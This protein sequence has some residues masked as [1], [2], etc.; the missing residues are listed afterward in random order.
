LTKR[1][2][3]IALAGNP[4]SGKSSLFNH[5]TGLKQKVSNIPGTSVDSKSGKWEMSTDVEAKVTDLPGIYSLLPSSED[6]RIASELLIRNASEYDLVIFSLDA[7]NVRRGL[8]LY[9]QIA[10]LG[11]PIVV[12]ISMTDMSEKMGVSV[13]IELLAQKLGV[14]IC[15][16]NTRS[17][18]GIK[19]LKS[20]ILK[21]AYG[22][23]TPI[24]EES[25]WELK[26][27]VITYDDVESS[28]ERRYNA[29]DKLLK[30]VVTKKRVDPLAFTKKADKII[31]HPVWGFMVFA[32]V[33]FIVFQLVFSFAEYPMEAIEWAFSSL[34]DFLN[35]RLP[36]NIFGELLVDGVLPG[37]GGVVVFLPQI[38]FL[39]ALLSILEETG[40]MSRVSFITDKIMRKVGLNGRSVIPMVGGLACA[41]PSIMAC[42]NI[43]NTKERLLTMLV[44]PLMS[45]SAR[46]PVYLLVISMLVPDDSYVWLFNTQGL[47]LFGLYILGFVAS[48][49]V[50]FFANIFVR[51]EGVTSYLMELPLYR[52]PQ[53]RTTFNLIWSK[54]ASFVKE[55]GRVILI[56]SVVLWAL[57]SYG[58]SDSMS[59][60]R[61][62]YSKLIY[63]NPDNEL[64][65]EKEMKSKLLEESYAG[66]IGKFI[67]PAIKPMGY[68]WKLGIGI[69]TSFA[70]RE[71]FVGT[72]ATIYSLDGEEN[73]KAL[74]KKM[75][76][77]INP[78]TGKPV[79]G[80][81]VLLS[82]LVF[83]AFAMQCSST[84]VILYKE[85]KGIKWPVIQFVYMSGLAYF[86]STLVY[87]FTI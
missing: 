21:G 42:R 85:T 30:G 16:V 56:V 8:L 40:Y 62:D 57:A 83:F 31:T 33:M 86:L 58:P 68:D 20:Q 64:A 9:S 6:E 76:S 87:Q 66:H 48:M 34:S 54:S 46:L 60:I 49:L 5:L 55:A 22:Y 4:N 41:V 35:A 75:K 3:N 67:E 53:V 32:A 72:M 63:E 29:I 13:D 19:N 12:L 71:V 84:L 26:D 74:R 15:P 18:K 82:I 79:Y 51:S 81:P 45:C 37:I 43:P 36:Q 1:K 44:L 27:G 61:K 65:L 47:I 52:V 11:V 28:T 39:F 23:H 10:N 69:L 59:N 25:G 17:G 2:L 77:E 24:I 50:A 14:I 73:L 38:V 7:T 80:I 70:A 78:E